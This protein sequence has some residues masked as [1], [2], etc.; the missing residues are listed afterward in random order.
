MPA[1]GSLGFF[2]R[3]S[4]PALARLTIRL[5][6][7]DTLVY[8]PFLRDTEQ[9]FRTTLGAGVDITTTGVMSILSR[10]LDAAIRSAAKSYVIAFVVITLMMIVLIGKLKLGL[11]SMLPNLTPIIVTI[12]LMWWIGIPLNMF[13]MLVGSIA[14]GI[15]VDDTI[16]FMHNFRRYFA[17]TGDVRVAVNRT[18][19][20]TGRAMLVTSVVLAIGFYIFLFASLNN[21]IQFGLLTGTAIVLALLADFLLAPALMVL[22]HPTPPRRQSATSNMENHR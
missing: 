7:R 22:L 11:A 18:L 5:P 21:V 19:H 3:A 1:V 6:W 12:G 4:R 13:T 10:T 8:V 9:R 16:H 15:A 2:N 17:E 14:I 20:T